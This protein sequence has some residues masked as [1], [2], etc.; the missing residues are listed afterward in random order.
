VVLAQ[1]E[2]RHPCFACPSCY[3]TA[4]RL[5]SWNNKSCGAVAVFRKRTRL[6]CLCWSSGWSS[7]RMKQWQQWRAQQQVQTLDSLT[8]HA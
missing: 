7:R 6:C 8:V 4:C 2:Q 3:I 1:L 5:T